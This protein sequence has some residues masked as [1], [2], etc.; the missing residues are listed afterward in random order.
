[1]C[2]EQYEKDPKKDLIDYTKYACVNASRKHLG[3]ATLTTVAIRDDHTIETTNLGDS[4]Y[5]LFHINPDNSV[6]MYFRSTEQQFAFNFPYQCG[7]EGNDPGMA[8][9]NSHE[10]QHGDIV[11]VFTDGF[12]DNVYDSG[13]KA[14]IEEHIYDGILVSPSA[15]ADCLAKKAY[16]L[17]LNQWYR[18]P[19][20]VNFKKAVDNNEEIPNGRPGPDYK[21]IG[22]KHDD[23]TV[24]V[25]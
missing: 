12:H 7:T 17:G 11:L 19:W 24:T 25:A 1:M 23:I 9:K 14:C 10:F 6:Q 8:D 13:F 18:S 15:A 4:G 22:G 21:F 20:M 5:A 2:V 3:T 16:W